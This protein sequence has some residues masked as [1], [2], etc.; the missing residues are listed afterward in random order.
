[1]QGY[2]FSLVISGNLGDIDA[3]KVVDNYKKTLAENQ[4]QLLS[5]ELWQ[6]RPLAYEIKKIATGVYFVLYFR[7]PGELI[8]KLKEQVSFDEFVLR[9]L[10]TKCDDI[11]QAQ[12][13]FKSLTADPQVNAKLYL[14]QEAQ[15]KTGSA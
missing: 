14:D 6:R 3:Q 12:A 7:G 9:S 15:M 5:C 10:I 13:V 2:E 4:A 11:E 8:A 1:M